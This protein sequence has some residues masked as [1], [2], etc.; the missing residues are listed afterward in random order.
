LDLIEFAIFESW[1]GTISVVMRNGRVVRLDLSEN[2]MYQ[3]HRAV[4]KRFPDGIESDRPFKMVRTLLHRYLKGQPVDFRDVEIDISDLPGF[5]RRVLE[6]LRKIP[7][8]ETRSYL[9][10]ARC[11]GRPSGGRAVGQAVKKNPIP[12]IV[13][14]HRVI[15]HDGS[16]GGFGLGEKIKKRLLFLEGVKK[17]WSV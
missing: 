3:E 1:F 14:C 2:D 12:I 11:A 5:T 15:R 16:L 17:T 8:G 4:L 10:I 7:Y 6:E 13:P 9:D